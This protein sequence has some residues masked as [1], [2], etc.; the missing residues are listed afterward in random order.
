MINENLNRLLDLA[1]G[2]RSQN[3]FALHCG[4]SSSALTR[5]KN[6]DYNTTPDFLKKVANRAHNGVT[7]KQLMIAAGFLTDE[8]PT[9]PTNLRSDVV[10]PDVLHQVG[11]GFS[12]QAE[13][14]LTQEQINEVAKFVKFLQ[15]D[16]K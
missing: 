3:E 11:I 12:K 9:P 1:K 16:E 2:Q 5:V 10:I 14:P 7:Y 6:G 8:K 13:K 15:N 4:V